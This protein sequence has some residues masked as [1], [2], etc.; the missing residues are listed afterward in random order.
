MSSPKQT[1]PVAVI[2]QLLDLT[3]RRV[4]Q[5]SAEGIIPKSERGRWE[6]VPAVKGYIRYLRDK[7]IKGD[8]GGD[9]SAHKQRLLKARADIA[10]M[11]AER[12]SGEL[13]SANAVEK[14]WTDI[15]ARFRVRILAIP[16]KAAPLVLG[17]QS[18][19]AIHATIESLVH[20]ALAEL[21]ATPI[22]SLEDEPRS[23]DDGGDEDGESSA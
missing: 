18:T 13:V 16:P 8:V 5:L 20:E 22:V 11:E 15:V 17:E 3:P 7:A 19:D 12:L 14:A 9:E 1:Y 4:N 2:A 23:S 6:L 21:A 10:E